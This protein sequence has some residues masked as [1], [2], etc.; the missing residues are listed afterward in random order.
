MN[1]KTSVA[2]CVP[3]RDTVNTGFAY[4]LAMLSARWYSLI[5]PGVKFSI[6]MNSGTLIADQR[7][8]LMSKAL[9]D[10]FEYV[11]FLDSDMRFPPNIIE[12]LLAHNKAVVACN[13]SQRRLP[14][15]PVAFYDFKKIKYV[16]S[17]NKTGIEPVA[18]IGMGVM[19][20]RL[21]DVANLPQPWFQI[22]YDANV[23]MWCGE[24]MF[25]CDLVTKGGGEVYVDHDTS[26]MIR[27]IGTFEYMHEHTAEFME[28]KDG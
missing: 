11:L 28:D 25:F 18:A 26:K 17:V 14:P 27:H 6:S 2:I 19:L 23:R 13:Y 10:G 1:M 9:A 7:Q 22:H 16:Y 21:R 24:D 12:K 8:K 3:A 5:E 15:K 4:D 20:I